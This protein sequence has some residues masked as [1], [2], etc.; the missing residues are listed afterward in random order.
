LYSKT[1]FN[2][3]T[4]NISLKDIESNLVRKSD[5]KEVASYL[6]LG[7]DV[8]ENGQWINCADAGLCLVG[9]G[10]WHAF[11]NRYQ[12]DSEQWYIDN[13]WWESSVNLNSEHEYQ[14]LLKTSELDE[15]MTL[16]LIDITDGNKQADSKTVDL[17]YA[18][19]D[20]SNTR[21]YRDL[22]ID[23]PPEVCRDE[24][25][26]PT[27]DW[28]EIIKYNTDENLYVRNVHCS[29]ARLYNLEGS[30]LWTNSYEDCRFLWPDK[31]GQ[32]GYACTK[33]SSIKRDYEDILTMD[34]N[35]AADN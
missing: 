29:D 27:D 25:G 1:G 15:K 9:N 4:F 5:G 24:Q 35:T 30:V 6:F 31:R 20:G 23:F 28:I 14:L 26:N 7:V 21:Y 18:K 13:T 8:Y 33:V 12:P 32:L 2:Q 22:A 11:V 16:S 17:R 3:A 19:K 34:M 10:K